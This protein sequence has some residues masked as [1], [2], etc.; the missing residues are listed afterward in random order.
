MTYIFLEDI[1][2][3]LNAGEVPNI[4]V[5]ITNMGIDNLLNAGEVPNMFPS[6]EPQLHRATTI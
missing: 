1:N 6:E 4:Y 2:N 3:L 5:I